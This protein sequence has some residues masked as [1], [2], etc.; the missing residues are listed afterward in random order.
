[1]RLRRVLLLLIVTTAGA[2]GILHLS[3][4]SWTKAVAFS[5]CPADSQA[6]GTINPQDTVAFWR[7]QPI[8]ALT[9]LAS[10][11]TDQQKQVLGATSE[12]KWIEIDLSDQKMTAHQGDQVFVESPVSTGLWNRTP[13]GDYRIWYKIRSTKMEG[14]NRAN[15]TYY[16][17]PNV[18][19]AMFF[20]GDIGIH[21]TYWHQNFGTPMSH[22]CVN[23]PTPI[24]EKLFYWTDPPLPEG[25]LWVKASA[26]QPGTQVVVHD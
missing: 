3:F 22:G 8:P 12:E 14:G 17:L 21:G 19:Y 11:L 9:G 10:L 20:A 26:D 13:V 5:G 18:P 6:E 7:N 2:L 25:K 16:Y 24:A 15:N 1:M 23:S 4:R